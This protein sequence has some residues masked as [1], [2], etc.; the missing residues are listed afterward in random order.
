[1]KQIIKST[2][3]LVSLVSLV[4]FGFIFC[5]P[6]LAQASWKFETTTTAIYDTDVSES[7]GYYDGFI[8]PQ[9]EPG[10]PGGP[11]GNNMG[12]PAG[13][14]PPR[15]SSLN[16]ISVPPDSGLA[17]SFELSRDLFEDDSAND[18]PAL[19]LGVSG[20]GSFYRTL[21][22]YN[23][24]FAQVFV[25]YTSAGED[26]YWEAKLN[27][28]ETWYAGTH[29]Q[30]YL[31]LTPTF[32]SKLSKELK[33]ETGIDLTRETYGNQST[34]F[35]PMATITYSWDRDHKVYLTAEYL[36]A[37][38]VKAEISK[39]NPPPAT[40][41]VIDGELFSIYD[42]ISGVAGC[43]FPGYLRTFLH[44]WG[45]VAQTNYQAE[46]LPPNAPKTEPRKDTLTGYGISLSRELGA[47]WLSGKIESAVYNNVS[48]GFN[49]GPLVSTTTTPNYSYNRA[50]TTVSLIGSF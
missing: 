25:D 41:H 20:F 27:Y 9:G 1:M 44:L 45:K 16:L 46:D 49:G 21:T 13:Q 29:Y 17:Q 8:S 10:G 23:Y 35:A 31:T 4:S 14:R 7:G 39:N 15:V 26:S 42:T 12:P 5:L 18:A 3:P 24:D 36:S 48:V 38:G 22:S 37:N 32:T 40:P 28:R 33:L 2:T 19:E 43:K 30:N 34:N 6:A 11:G 50:V 47:K